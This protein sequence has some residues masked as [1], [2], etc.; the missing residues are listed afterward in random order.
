MFGFFGKKFK[1]PLKSKSDDPIVQ[2]FIESAYFVNENC[3]TIVDEKNAQ[4]R[5]GWAGDHNCVS[6]E[7]EK[8]ARKCLWENLGK[9]IEAAADLSF[10]CRPPDIDYKGEIEPTVR[11]LGK[12][13]KAEIGTKLLELE[14]EASLKAALDKNKTLGQ[15]FLVQRGFMKCSE[16]QGWLKELRVKLSELESRANQS[17]FK[18]QV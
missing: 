7:I 2:A 10:L 1:I 14:K 9:L 13:Y 8:K 3:R 4:I 16:A 5:F 6:Y 12:L 15:I 11:F 17:A 18:S